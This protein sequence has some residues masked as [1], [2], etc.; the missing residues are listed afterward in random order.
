VTTTGSEDFLNCSSLRT[1]F[2]LPD[3]AITSLVG[4]SD[5]VI[6]VVTLANGHLHG[7]LINLE[8][9]TVKSI[10]R[11]S[12]SAL[13]ASSAAL[14]A[15]VS[16]DYL[17]VLI[18]STVL[19]LYHLTGGDAVLLTI[20]VLETLGPTFGAFSENSR[21]FWII[22][23]SFYGQKYQLSH[24][25]PCYRV[26]VSQLG[27]PKIGTPSAV[28]AAFNKFIIGTHNGHVVICDWTGEAP[29]DISVSHKPIT[30]ITRSPDHAL[31]ALMDSDGG[32]WLIQ[33]ESLAVSKLT[34][35]SHILRFVSVNILLELSTCGL[36]FHAARDFCVVN[37][38][39]TPPEIVVETSEHGRTTFLTAASRPQP[40]AD[41]VA[42]ARRSHLF[43]LAELLTCLLPC[44]FAPIALGVNLAREPMLA[45][46]ADESSVIERA[47]GPIARR[48]LA[49]NYILRG[50][51]Q[52]A[53]AFL[54]STPVDSHDFALE[55][56]KAVYVAQPGLG[57]AAGPIV[58][59][60]LAGGRSHDAVDIALFTDQ[61]QDAAR[62]LLMD[63]N[64]VGA[65]RILAVGIE[66]GE[67]A[68]NVQGR[69]EAALRSSGNLLTLS[70][71]MIAWRRFADAAAVLSEAGME[72]EAGILLR[73]RAVDEDFA[74][75][76]G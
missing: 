21:E 32:V 25:E 13:C 70:G 71:L 47:P 24:V 54:L 72:A 5:E 51:R 12:L 10:L 36:T 68:R 31:C 40:A 29:T 42:A 27:N 26:R 66:D 28:A 59:A 56:A 52:E 57:H 14:T 35:H 1:Y 65:V 3:T 60:L 23:S 76:D 48:R 73:L 38:P 6:V 18:D 55:V 62:L 20:E 15:S 37:P 34:S 39:G 58:A 75:G 22:D 11:Q 63:G 7:F 8:F 17:S 4:I 44:S 49:R 2:R 9:R 41:L 61:F 46:L 69:V 64:L 50:A 19:A 43:C 30:A 67:G 16:R 74:V 33:L 45:T 53:F